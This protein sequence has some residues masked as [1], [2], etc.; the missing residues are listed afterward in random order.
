MAGLRS[1]AGRDLVENLKLCLTSGFG[2]GLMPIGHGPG[3]T[4]RTIRLRQG[5]RNGWSRRSR[6]P[7]QPGGAPAVGYN[8][9]NGHD[10]K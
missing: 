9:M 4:R 8:L 1:A 5:G 2:S 3:L 6:Q 7:V 10:A